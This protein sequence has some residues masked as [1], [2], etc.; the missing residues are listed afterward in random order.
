MYTAHLRNLVKK[1]GELSLSPRPSVG[2]AV[3][4]S[5][6]AMSDSSL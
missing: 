1:Q 2:S 6:E 3:G 4:L 5:V